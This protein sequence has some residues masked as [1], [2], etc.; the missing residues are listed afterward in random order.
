MLLHGKA[1]LNEQFEKLINTA[2]ATRYA[3]GPKRTPTT[4]I[5]GRPPS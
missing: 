2:K 1:A 5:R 3:S 4:K